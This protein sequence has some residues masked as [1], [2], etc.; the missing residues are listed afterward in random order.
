[1]T[2]THP[3][4]VDETRWCDKDIRRYCMVCGKRWTVER[5]KLGVQ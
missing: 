4:I 5:E 1:M 2:C 3:E